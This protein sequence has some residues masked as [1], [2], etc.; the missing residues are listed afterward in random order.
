MHWVHAHSPRTVSSNYHRK[1][2]KKNSARLKAHDK[3]STKAVS[4]AG[5]VYVRYISH[6]AGEISY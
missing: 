5:R 4:L 1:F 6:T 3:E 2:D